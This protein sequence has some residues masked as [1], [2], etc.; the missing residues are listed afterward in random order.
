MKIDAAIR[1]IMREAQ[2]LLEVVDKVCD[3]T[4]NLAASSEE[5]A[6]SSTNVADISNRIKQQLDVLVKDMK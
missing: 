5:I 4:Q 3:R 6:A 2:T 1:S